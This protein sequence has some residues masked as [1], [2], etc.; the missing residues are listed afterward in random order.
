MTT[1]HNQM[2]TVQITTYLVVR[3]EI[4]Q[5]WTG[6]VCRGRSNVWI[7]VWMNLADRLHSRMIKNKI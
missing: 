5:Q 6:V 2:T 4:D 3:I 7:E 1:Y